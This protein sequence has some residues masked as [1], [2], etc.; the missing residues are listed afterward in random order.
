M[1]N[2]KL[3]RARRVVGRGRRKG[4]SIM[5]GIVHAKDMQKHIRHLE[6]RLHIAEHRLAPLEAHGLVD[7]LSDDPGAFA[8]WLTWRPPGHFYSTV[9]NLHELE[10]HADQ[11]WTPDMGR[12]VPGV[13]LRQKSQYERFERIASFS[14]ELQVHPNRTDPYR[15]FSDNVSYGIG[16][17]LTLHGMLRDIRPAHMIEI[18]SGHSS[19]MT[20]DT[21]EFFLDGKTELTFIEPYPELLESL[22]KPGDLDR[23]SIVTKDLQDVPLATFDALGDGD[24]LFIDSTHVL[25]TGSD[26]VYLYNRLLPILNEGVY[27]HIHD[28]FRGF[29]YPKP[30]VMEGRA[31]GEDYIVQAFLSLNQD[32]EIL[33]F[34]DWLGAF[35]R[36]LIEAHL[37]AMLANPGGAMWLRRVSKWNT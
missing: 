13:D 12:E 1:S 21:V 31:W 32:F 11:L 5:N 17:A 8:R 37:P 29:E 6:Q 18:G 22:L 14:R 30:W 27:V 19:A 24:V 35:H 3:A 2:S 26:V 9:P 15:Y 23:I 10:R 7:A 36:D 25:R 28:I 4:R 16:D 33:L 20:L 34:N